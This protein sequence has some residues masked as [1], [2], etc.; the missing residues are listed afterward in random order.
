MVVFTCAHCGESLQKPKVEKHYE[1]K[2]RN[3]NPDLC[4]MD[5]LKD[6]RGDEYKVH[7]KCVSEAE[8]YGGKGFIAKPGQNKGERKQNAWLEIVQSVLDENTKLSGTL[9]QL[10]EKV[11]QQPN[12]PRKKPKFIN[13]IRS[14]DY[15]IG[16]KDVESAWELL[17]AKLNLLKTV[18]EP[19]QPNPAVAVNSE[20]I[21]KE[22]TLEAKAETEAM[23]VDGVSNGTFKK[24]KKSKKNKENESITEE[25]TNG[26][27]ADEETKNAEDNK[28]E[29]ITLTKK[30]KKEKKKK[31]KYEAELK[32]AAQNSTG[33]QN[34]D[35]EVQRKGKKR[36]L[37]QVTEDPVV[38]MQVAVEEI[39]LNG[40]PKKKKTKE[41]SEG[42]NIADAILEVLGSKGKDIALKKLQKKVLTEY[43]VVHGVSEIPERISK[44]FTR[45]LYK[46]PNLKVENDKVRLIGAEE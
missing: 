40:E 34:G 36:K 25:Q 19:R 35:S 45:T 26:D 43:C 28:P 11:A 17:S 41:G 33:V 13:F 2:C 3:R 38:A 32:A 30:E 10:L 24:A 39:A 9:R 6:F 8:R 15:R 23:E 37:N 12:T 18:P 4:C 29:E 21:V 44:K 46:I 14:M 27:K 20:V 22:E 5:C 7:T 1:T 42:F 16:Q 31:E